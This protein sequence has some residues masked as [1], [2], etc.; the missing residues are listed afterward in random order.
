MFLSPGNPHRFLALG[1]PV[2][3][4]VLDWIG[5]FRGEAKPASRHQIH[6][7]FDGHIGC[8]RHECHQILMFRYAA[9]F[10][11][12]FHSPL[13]PDLTVRYNIVGV[14]TFGASF[15]ILPPIVA[16]ATATI[17]VPATL[18]SD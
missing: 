9:A 2:I 18:S 11:H 13:I 15:W 7:V 16:P 4:R 8:D 12:L 17:G 6:L 14:A 10:H 3:K 1:A 5:A